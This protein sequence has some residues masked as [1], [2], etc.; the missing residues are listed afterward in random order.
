M[1]LNKED[2]A[3]VKNAMGKALAN[4]VEGV[5]QDHRK[6]EGLKI[7][8]AHGYMSHSDKQKAAMKL[9]K[10]KSDKGLFF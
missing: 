9:A 1:A 2:K 10:R 7:A 8:K 4:K 6:K 5:T 3:D